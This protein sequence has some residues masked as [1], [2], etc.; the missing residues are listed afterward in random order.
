MTPRHYLCAQEAQEA[1][2][3]RASRPHRRPARGRVFWAH[4]FPDS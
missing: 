4:A 3:P 2:R 1:P